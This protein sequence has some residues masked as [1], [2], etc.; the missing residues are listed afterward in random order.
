[1]AATNIPKKVPNTYFGR[2]LKFDEKDI[3]EYNAIKKKNAIIWVTEPPLNCVTEIKTDIKPYKRQNSW[4]HTINSVASVLH[5]LFSL[6]LS[7]Y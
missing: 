1:M 2:D 7:I 4:K 6:V 3:F 5:L